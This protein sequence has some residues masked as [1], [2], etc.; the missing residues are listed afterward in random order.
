VQPEVLSGRK[1]PRTVS[2][3]EYVAFGLVARQHHLTGVT[4][5]SRNVLKPDRSYIP[6]FYSVQIENILLSGY[7]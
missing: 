5:F 6:I 1:I 7:F 2:G 3:I 4:N